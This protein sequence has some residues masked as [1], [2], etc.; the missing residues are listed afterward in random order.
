MTD[1]EL[2]ELGAQQRINEL[3]EELQEL[4]RRFPALA[5]PRFSKPRHTPAEA[6][7]RPARRHRKPM[8]KAQRREVSRRMKAWWRGKK[9]E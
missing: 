5:G 7:E 1:Q 3:A 4:R 2:V 6:A 8:T 9:G